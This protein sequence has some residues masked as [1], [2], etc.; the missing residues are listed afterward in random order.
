VRPGAVRAMVETTNLHTVSTL[1]AVAAL[2]R[3]ESRGCHR[4]FDHPDP[5]P[6]WHRHQLLRY[7]DGEIQPVGLDDRV[8]A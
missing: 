3:T 4:R 2:E 6:E 7:L 1:T 5:R 8:A